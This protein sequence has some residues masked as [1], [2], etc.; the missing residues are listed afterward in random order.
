LTDE[1][2]YEVVSFDWNG[3]FD[4]GGLSQFDISRPP[5]TLGLTSYTP[6][7]ESFAFGFWLNDW[8]AYNFAQIQGVMLVDYRGQPG[9]GQSYYWPIDPYF[10]YFYPFFGN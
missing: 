3:N 1:F 8:Y 5:M 9:A 4:Y 2:E 6:L 10:D 7:N